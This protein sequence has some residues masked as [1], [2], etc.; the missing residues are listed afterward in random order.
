MQIQSQNFSSAPEIRYQLIETQYRL[1]THIHQFAELVVLLEGELDVTV[2]GTTERMIPGQAAFVFPFQPHGY[3]SEVKNKLALILFSPSLIP[4]FFRETAGTV[5]ERS[6]FTP[7]DSTFAALNKKIISAP[8]L[9]LSGVKGCLYLA[10]DDFVCAT[11]MKKASS[12]SNMSAGVVSYINEHMTED[13]TLNSIAAALGYSPKYLSNCIGKLFGMNL[14]TLIAAIRVNKAKYLLRET[15][16][17]GLEIMAEC[18]FGT[19]RS[20]HRQ[21]KAV[22]GRTPKYIREKYYSGSKIDQGIVKKFE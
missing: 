22:L 16:K 12:E 14:R 8:D 18:G 5:G 20:F 3:R 19:E 13:L 7:S 9:T 15:D 6:V 2:D 10:L 21:F 11:P 1:L 17:T 4:N